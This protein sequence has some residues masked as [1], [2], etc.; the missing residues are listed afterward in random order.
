MK[1]VVLRYDKHRASVRKWKGFT[2]AVKS[3]FKNI[4]YGKL[5][6]IP[7]NPPSFCPHFKTAIWGSSRREKRKHTCTV[8]HS[9]NTSEV[10]PELN[11]VLS[12]SLEIFPVTWKLHHFRRL[13][14]YFLRCLHIECKIFS[15]MMT[16][17]IFVFLEHKVIFMNK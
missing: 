11:T 10:K 13:V 3:L 14:T 7:K 12:L 1:C 5:R 15:A 8:F 6:D 9:V 4:F 16:F 2:E 17:F